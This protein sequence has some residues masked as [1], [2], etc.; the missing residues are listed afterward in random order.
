MLSGKFSTMQVQEPWWFYL[1]M[2]FTFCVFW[3]WVYLSSMKCVCLFVFCAVLAK[4]V[5]FMEAAKKESIM[6]IV[7]K[8]YLYF[9]M[10][11][12]QL[13]KL[14]GPIL[15]QIYLVHALS[16]YFFKI[17][18]TNYPLCL[19][20]PSGP[21]TSGFPAKNLYASLFLPIRAT[22]VAHLILLDLFTRATFCAKCWQWMSLVRTSL[23]NASDLHSS[24]D[25]VF[26]S[27]SRQMRK[28][29]ATTSSSLTVHYALLVRRFDLILNVRM[30]PNVLIPGTVKKI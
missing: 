26:W 23:R 6:I 7:C 22:C 15:S 14:L 19:G 16:S 12:K 18:F 3:D 5:V 27:S 8:S 11:I 1:P 25:L 28:A 24:D 9:K 30:D 29:T 20:L 17:H 21:F 13:I 10:K 2:I 4:N